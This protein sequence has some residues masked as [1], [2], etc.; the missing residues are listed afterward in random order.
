[1]HHHR[2]HH[3]GKHLCHD[4]TLDAITPGAVQ[5]LKRGV[6]QLDRIRVFDGGAGAGTSQLARTPCSRSRGS[7]FRR[8][9]VRDARAHG[10][11]FG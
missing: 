6:W 5:E 3:R 1:M 4:T 7:S 11:T 10:F 9:C 8:R 2:E